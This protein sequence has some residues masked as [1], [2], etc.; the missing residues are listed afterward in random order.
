[1]LTESVRAV[2]SAGTDHDHLHMVALLLRFTISNCNARLQAK[3]DLKIPNALD[4]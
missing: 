3:K 1:M 4:L 2:C